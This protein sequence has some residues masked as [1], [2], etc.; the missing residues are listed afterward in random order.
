RLETPRPQLVP[1]E[2]SGADEVG[3]LAA[4]FNRVQ[5]VAGELVERQLISRRN[6]AT[7]FG[8][9]GRRTQNLVGRQLGMIDELERNE[10]DPTLLERL[11]RIDHVST[12]LRRNANC[13]VVLS[14]SADP[15][16][17]SEPL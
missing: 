1:V 6:V 11:Y 15:E 10:Q 17:V 8:N 7:M 16:I 3:E 4:A 9:V 2:V 13:L 5:Q 12:R 14:G